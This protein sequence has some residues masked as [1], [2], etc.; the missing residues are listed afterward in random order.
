MGARTV[1]PTPVFIFLDENMPSVQDKTFSGLMNSQQRKI[2]TI[3]LPAHFRGI[4]YP[5]YKVVLWMKR[6]ILSGWYQIGSSFSGEQKPVFIFC[7]TD[8]NFIEDAWSEM[9]AEQFA[10]GKSFGIYYFL[11][12]YTIGFE[13]EEGEIQIHVCRI[14]Q[15]NGRQKHI[16]IN[17]IIQQVRDILLSPQLS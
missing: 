9:V 4:K 10:K 7:T 17:Q 1:D 2:T 15:K 14:R 11:K 6:A 8:L 16:L 5:D 12:S 13:P 3:S